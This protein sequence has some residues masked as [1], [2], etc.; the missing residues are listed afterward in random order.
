MSKDGSPEVLETM[1]GES[2]A[3]SASAFKDIMSGTMGGV[4]QGEQDLFFRKCLCCCQ[5]SR[6]LSEWCHLPFRSYRAP[7][8]QTHAA[9]HELGNEWKL[10]FQR[11]SRSPSRW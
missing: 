3:A 11:L 10:F 6:L 7:D 8:S 4:A 9:S 1:P 2:G 5:D